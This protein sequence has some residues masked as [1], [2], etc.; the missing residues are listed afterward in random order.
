MEDD[1]PWWHDSPSLDDLRARQRAV[2]KKAAITAAEEAEAREARW[3]LRQAKWEELGPLD[4]N[5]AIWRRYKGGGVT[6]KGV[7]DEFGIGPERVR[8]II[9]R[10]DRKVKKA[11]NHGW[12]NVPDEIREA[13]LGVEF[14]FT[15]EMALDDRRGW[16]Q[17]EDKKCGS[18]YLP[19]LPE[20][21]PEWG[22]QDA[23]P[24]LPRVLYT[25]YKVTIPKEQ[26]NGC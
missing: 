21:H 3:K 23:E 8:Q 6:L 14:V 9:I 16:D 15:N 17:L 13:T 12:N 18:K 25:Y 24:E 11:L 19:P 7:G 4:R 26:A 22:A 10:L 20:W 5:W 1:P 2:A